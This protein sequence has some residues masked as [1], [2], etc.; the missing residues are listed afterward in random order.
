MRKKGI[1][2]GPGRQV[3]DYEKGT[4]EDSGKLTAG[5][6]PLQLLTCNTLG[7]T[8]HRREGWFEKKGKTADG[9]GELPSNVSRGV[10]RQVPTEGTGRKK[11]RGEEEK[12]V[13][14][15]GRFS[16]SAAT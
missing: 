11:S 8:G 3:L 5:S 2:N 10:K 13:G 9:K 14:P 1:Q 4:S 15:E 6:S 7:T 12:E 16:G